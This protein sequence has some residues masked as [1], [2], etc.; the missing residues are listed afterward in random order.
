MIICVSYTCG[1]DVSRYHGQSVRTTAYPDRNERRN[2]K[3]IFGLELRFSNEPRERLFGVRQKR[4][5][6]RN[7]TRPYL[8]TFMICASVGRR[9]SPEKNSVECS[10]RGALQT[11]IFPP[12]PTIRHDDARIVPDQ[13]RIR[14]RPAPR[15]VV[16]SI[17]FL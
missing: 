13:G 6:D 7:R 1:V 10:F 3:T 5:F 14:G 17:F 12:A 4:F 9:F 11:A 16:N 15:Y 2:R 8:L